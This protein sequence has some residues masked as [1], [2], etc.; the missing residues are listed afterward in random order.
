[1]EQH[2]AEIIDDPDFPYM[3]LPLSHRVAIIII[4]VDI[5]HPDQEEDQLLKHL[6]DFLL[7]GD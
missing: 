5:V 7:V 4:R 2:V 6:D 1:M 3:L